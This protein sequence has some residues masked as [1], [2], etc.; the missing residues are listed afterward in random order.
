MFCID[1]YKSQISDKR[2]DNVWYEFNFFVELLLK[3]NPN[4]LEAL[5]VPEDKVIGEIHPLMKKIREKKNLFLTKQCFNSFYQYASEQVSKARG[6][7]K[8]IVNPIKKRLGPLDFTYTFYKQGSQKIEDWLDNRGLKTKYCGLVN[9][10]HMH[11]IYGLYYDFGNHAFHETGWESDEKFLNFVLEY[12]N[13]SNGDLR[14]AIEYINNLHPIGYRGLICDD[15]NTTQLR[16][17]SVENKDDIP[18]C[19]I[20][21]NASGFTD[22][23]RKYKQYKEWEEN[24]NPVRYESNLNKNYDSKNMMHCFRLMQMAIEIAKG[25][26]M[27]LVR[28]WDHNFLM[29]IRNHKY[30]YDE[31]IKILEEKMAEMNEAMKAS[32]LP[33]SIDKE[34]VNKL[35]IDIRCE[36]MSKYLN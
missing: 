35:L 21:F 14:E 5:F 34:E 11:D 29:D 2:K 1:K 9:I 36:Q 25:E 6:L 4:I 30:E 15:D 28:T 31:L 7:N 8:K 24:R 22:H 16:L 32:K 3:A 12:S 23:C 18:L 13:N 10:P 19:H 27:N 20:S 26:G 33:E 17:S